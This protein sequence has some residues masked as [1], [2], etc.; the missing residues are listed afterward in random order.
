MRILSELLNEYRIQIIALVAGS[1]S[2]T[3]IYERLVSI[4][5]LQYL[6]VPNA[7]VAILI[8]LSVLGGFEIR[9]MSDRLR[10]YEHPKLTDNMEYVLWMHKDVPLGNGQCASTLIE[11]Q[12]SLHY[13]DAQY[14]L[15][16]LFQMGFLR[17]INN[18]DPDEEER[19]YALAEPGRRYLVETGLLHKVFSEDSSHNKNCRLS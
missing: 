16:E 12:D 1:V 2:I 10:S 11:D 5:Y 15:D 19:L 8:L 6:E 9:R 17:V 14:C 13:Q 4:F 18:P 7:V 3:A